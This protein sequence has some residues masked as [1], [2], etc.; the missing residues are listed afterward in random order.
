MSVEDLYRLLRNGH[1]Q[2][3]GIVDTIDEPLVVLD[4]NFCVSNANRAFFET[5]LIDRGEIIG[6]SFFDLGK[7]QWNVPELKALLT[8]VIR[9][10]AVVVGFEVVCDTEGEPPR[11]M[12]VSARKLK[13]DSESTSMLLVID[14][15]TES[16]RA[17]ATKDIQLAEVQHRMKNLLTLV[18][19]LAHQIPADGRSGPEYREAF[20][21]RFEAILNAQDLSVFGQGEPDLATLITRMLEPVEPS[22][23]MINQGPSVALTARQVLPITMI[24]HELVTNAVKYG[25]LSEG[26]GQVSVSWDIAGEDSGRIAQIDWREEGGP[27]VIAP[28][29]SGF[30][31][32]LIQFSAKTSLGGVA[33]LNYEPDGLRARIS[34][35]LK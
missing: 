16:R 5:F 15:V 9:E 26:H 21:G 1:V 17:E 14:D 31:S 3:Q 2:A 7:G 35:P 23:V 33:E 12:L 25:A 29:K 4:R 10:S 20:L 34:F 28:H 32:N 18:R 24:V 30:G 19:A 22:R 27:A 13:S 6:E 11:T 8:S